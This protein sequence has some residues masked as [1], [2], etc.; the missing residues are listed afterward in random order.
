M[1]ETL[2]QRLQRSIDDVAKIARRHAREHSSEI[3]DDVLSLYRK[4]LA[5]QRRAD[6]SAAAQRDK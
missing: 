1:A 5:H 2:S 6:K 3:A 4:L